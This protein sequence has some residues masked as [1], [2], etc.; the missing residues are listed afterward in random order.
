MRW[1]LGILDRYVGRRF[2]GLYGLCLMFFVLL[3]MVVDGVGRIDDFIESSEQMPEGVSVLPLALEFYLNRIPVFSVLFAPYL[4]L[5]AAIACLMTFSR[6]NELTAM[7]ASGRSLHRILLPVYV[8]AV[9]I[10][11]MLLVA[12]EHV[13][14]A[15]LSRLKNVEM[16]LEGKEAA[17]G[18]RVPHLRDGTNTFVARRW[19]ME[20][21]RLSDVRCLSYCDEAGDGNAEGA[22]PPGRLVADA[23]IYRRRPA[24]GLEAW[25]PVGGELRP[26]G[27]DADGRLREPIALPPDQPVAFGLTPTTIAVLVEEDVASLPS[28]QIR[29]LRRLYPDKYAELSMQLYSR[30]TRPMANFVLL[31]LGLPFV[32]RPGQRSIA[33]GLAVAF[34]CCLV[35]ITFDLFCAELGAR[36]EFHPLVASWLTPG[37]FFAVGVARLDRIIT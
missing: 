23:L 31:L 8:S 4:T 6:H 20:D 12:E 10:T 27:K 19:I 7:I 1:R 34:G 14:P 13:I 37:L 11:G 16:R 18:E 24:D 3:F 26:L 17:R 30:R 32:A 29:E 35:Y 36:G 21:L 15:A 2:L 25:F 22:L 9:V 33:S 5:F 28:D